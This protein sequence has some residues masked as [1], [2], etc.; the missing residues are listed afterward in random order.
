M[1]GILL[2]VKRFFSVEAPKHKKRRN[3]LILSG[4]CAVL[5]VLFALGY[6]VVYTRSYDIM[7]KTPLVVFDVNETASGTVIVVLGKEYRV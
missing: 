7:N 3:A 4:F 1:Y 2:A 6:G 5:S